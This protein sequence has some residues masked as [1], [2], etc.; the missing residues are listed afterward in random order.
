ML[1]EFLSV[2]LNNNH[3]A[4]AVAKAIHSK[5]P[6]LDL[7]HRPEFTSPGLSHVV[8]EVALKN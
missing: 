2:Q 3:L 7:A 4:I 5:P 8:P 1:M 6:D